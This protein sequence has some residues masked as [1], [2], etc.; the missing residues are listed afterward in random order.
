MANSKFEYVKAFE[1]EVYLLPETYM[2]VRV[3]GRGFHKLS[4]TYKFEKPNDLN[5]LELMNKAAQS[6]MEKIP[7]ALLAYGDSDEYSFLLQKNCE[8]FERREAKLT[9]TF[10]S[11]FTAY[12]NFYWKDYFPNSPLTPERL[13]TFDARV[14]L[15]PNQQNVKDYFSWRQVDCHINNLYNTTFWQLILKKGLTPQESEKRLMGT[16]S[17]DKNEIL[18]TELG[19]N[20]NDEAEIYKKG[21]VLIREWELKDDQPSLNEREL[22]KRQKDRLRKKF[23]KAKIQKYHI[24]IINEGFWNERPWLLES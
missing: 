18:F 14:V 8:I 23:R 15:Y 24:D 1:K 20:Y 7:E 5:A 10:S 22:S 11:T 12:Y 19:I 3:D 21:T 6:V 17:S 2:V 9:S 13:P 16:L 4:E